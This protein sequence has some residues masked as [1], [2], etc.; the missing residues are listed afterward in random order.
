[1]SCLISNGPNGYV[2]NDNTNRVWEDLGQFVRRYQEF[3]VHPVPS[4]LNGECA[5]EI[6]YRRLEEVRGKEHLASSEAVR[7]LPELPESLGA[8]VRECAR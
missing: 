2:V 6:E 7:V 1:M 5:R 3:F 4:R 8:S